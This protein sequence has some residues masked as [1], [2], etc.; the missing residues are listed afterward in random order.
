M[1]LWS[2]STM[3]GV[4]ILAAIAATLLVTVA[5]NDAGEHDFWLCFTPDW[6]GAPITLQRVF[7]LPFRPLMWLIR[8]AVWNWK[9]R[10]RRRP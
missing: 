8:G 4:P 2:K 3:D 9:H 7:A 10:L 1:T 6:S 5:V